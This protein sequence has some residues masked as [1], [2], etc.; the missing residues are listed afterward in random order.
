[1]GTAEAP[2]IGDNVRGQDYTKVEFWPDLKRFD[3]EGLDDD[4]VA[5]LSRRAYDLAGT[6]RGVTI[7]LNGD[8]IPVTNLLFVCQM[9]CHMCLR[10][11]LS[12][13]SNLHLD[14]AS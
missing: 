11:C 14:P 12:M 7:R 2:V 5:L 13:S 1:M 9:F 8:K 4:F 10:L 6:V 3:L